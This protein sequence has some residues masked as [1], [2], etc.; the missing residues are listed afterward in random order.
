MDPA[1]ILLLALAALCGGFTQGLAGFGST[2]VALP[3]LALVL[4]LR[5]AV[6]VCC[7]LAIAINIILTSRLRGHIVWP[8]L[9]LLIGASLPGLVI[10]THLLRSVPGDLLK[11]ALGAAVL[12]FVAGGLRGR[13]RP[14]RAGRR[15]ALA[16]G[17]LAGCMGG[18]IGVN[19]PPIAAWV[20][21]QG[22]DRF[23][24]RATMT[25]YFL[26]AGIGVVSSQYVAGLLTREVLLKT[27]VAVPAM[28]VGL[29]LGMACCGR[30]GE[31]TF[32][33]IMLLV[34]GLSGASLL[35][36]ALLGMPG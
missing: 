17:F 34:L 8:A 25:A 3:L 14:G 36:Q 20:S 4:D 6:P 27:A 24:A 7:L 29:G 13:K 19:G 16:A 9:A 28:A 18:A 1:I 21:R 10:G 22:Y 33:R 26:L 31:G 2:L 5:V 32:S 11:G 30:I 23:A 15:T 35:A 12:V